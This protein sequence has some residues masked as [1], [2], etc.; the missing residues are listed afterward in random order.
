MN[1]TQTNQT[2]IKKEKKTNAFKRFFNKHET[3]IGITM[4]ISLTSTATLGAGYYGVKKQED[5]LV[6]KD[7]EIQ[8]VKEDKSETI[9]FKEPLSKGTYS[10]SDDLAHKMFGELEQKTEVKIG[11]ETFYFLSFVSLSTTF[12][13][14]KP[15][16]I[17]KN[18]ETGKLIM[19]YENSV[20]EVKVNGETKMVSITLD[21]VDTKEDKKLNGIKI[22]YF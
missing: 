8:N 7:V 18:K 6:Y 2:E 22:K 16:V 15:I 4:A 11:D 5:N 12:D 9:K 14:D 19:V 17:L 10:T 13:K 21:T 1:K 20:M 3:A